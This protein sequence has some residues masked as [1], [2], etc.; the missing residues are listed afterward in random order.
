MR[1]RF[2]GLSVWTQIST[3]VLRTT[4]VVPHNQNA[5]TLL[6]V[7]TVYAKLDTLDQTAQVD[8]TGHIRCRQLNLVAQWRST[9]CCYVRLST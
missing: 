5:S 2:A 3:N 1:G 6:E 4:E 7:S 9:F 8:T